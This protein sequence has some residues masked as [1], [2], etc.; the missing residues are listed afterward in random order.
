VIIGQS[1]NSLVGQFVASAVK[2]AA[3]LLTSAL[4]KFPDPGTC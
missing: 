4:L 2:P 1:T 3:Q